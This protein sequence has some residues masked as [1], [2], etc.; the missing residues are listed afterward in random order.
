MYA[1]TSLEYVTLEV[2]D[3]RPLVD[4]MSCGVPPLP[5]HT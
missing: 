2:D 1:M 4:P 5:R 3:P